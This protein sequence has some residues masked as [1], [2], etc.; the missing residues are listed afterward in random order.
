MRPLP[1]SLVPNLLS[2]T[3]LPLAAA[4]LLSTRTGPRVA[5]IIAAA[6][7]DYLDGW[8]ARNRGGR[9]QSG[10]LLDPLTDKIFVV[11]A[12][13]SFIRHG[14]LT[15]AQLAVLLSRDLFVAVAFIFVKLRGVDVPLESRFPGKVVTTLQLAALLVLTL[16]PLAATATVVATGIASA[17]AIVDYSG[18]GLRALRAPPRNR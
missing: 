14:L 1:P 12:L 11:V 13:A 6:A 3:R 17:W 18:V 5:I 2:L 4:F 7:S 16:L 15:T 8:W 9:S 10:A